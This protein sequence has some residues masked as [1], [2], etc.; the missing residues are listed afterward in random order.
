MSER[1]P[2][3]LHQAACC[4]VFSALIAW[5][6]FLC[7]YRGELR[8][9]CMTFAKPRGTWHICCS[10]GQIRFGRGRCGEPDVGGALLCDHALVGRL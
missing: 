6:I 9:S 3:A 10:M 5:R 1:G 8:A 4:T 2:D 7:L